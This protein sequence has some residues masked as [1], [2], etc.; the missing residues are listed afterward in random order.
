M[1][2]SYASRNRFWTL[3]KI[4][5]GI[6]GRRLYVRE[7]AL[8]ASGELSLGTRLNIYEE[9]PLDYWNETAPNLNDVV[10]IKVNTRKVLK[11]SRVN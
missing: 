8:N 3:L 9:I 7:D 10:S 1:S 5:N 2:F 11:T 4:E 6:L